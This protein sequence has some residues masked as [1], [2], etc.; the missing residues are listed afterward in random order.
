M[1]LGG[2]FGQLKIVLGAGKYYPYRSKH[3]MERILSRGLAA[4]LEELP[5]LGRLSN[6]KCW[7]LLGNKTRTER[8]SNNERQKGNKRSLTR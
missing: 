8:G 7:A 2:A 4:P 5:K 3:L 6:E 1:Q